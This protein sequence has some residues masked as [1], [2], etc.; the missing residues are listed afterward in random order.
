LRVLHLV[1]Y[2]HLFPPKN[3]G[4]LRCWNL[5]NQLF[6]Y[7]LDVIT[8]QRDIEKK[9]ADKGFTVSSKTRFLVPEQSVD[10][11]KGT[12]RSIGKSLTA[13]KYRWF[14]NTL[15]SVDSNFLEIIPVIKSISRDKYDI[16]IFEHL[17][18]LIAW[19]KI[20]RFFPNAKIIF[21]AHNVDHILLSNQRDNLEL[22][23]I[24][25][26]EASLYNKCDLILA[27]STKDAGVFEEINQHKIPVYIVPN[28]IDT[29][30]NPYSLPDFSKSFQ[31]IFCG[32]LDYAPNQLGL[33]WF[34]QSVWPV[35]VK[36]YPQIVLMIVGR[37][38]PGSTLSALLQNQPSIH[39]IGE[40]DDT[41]PYYRKAQCS[42]VPLLHGSGTRLKILEAMSLGIPVISTAV[43]AE[44]IRY[45][46]GENIIIA[47]TANEFS[48]AIGRLYEQPG[49]FSAISKNGRELVE[50]EYSWDLIGKELRKKLMHFTKD[51]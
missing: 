37:G 9:I 28:G 6:R 17:E 20:K 15:A 39:F 32:S 5:I 3:G 26:Q 21:D 11:K 24:K 47:E 43:G 7:D 46:N 45:S 10:L 2:A 29:S 27:C 12:N 22:K 35:M 30:L 33:C 51:T 40:V 19:K 36:K 8:L 41:I 23:K 25:E 34:L 4:M 1:M 42:I 31:F 14:Y 18:S 38:N 49:Y 16:V 48:A 44:G 50:Q 13:G